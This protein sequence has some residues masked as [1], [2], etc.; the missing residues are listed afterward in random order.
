MDIKNQKFLVLGASKSG[1]SVLKY[2]KEKGAECRVYEE[3]KNPKAQ[4][5]VEKLA[6]LGIK[7]V[8]KEIAEDFLTCVDVL[9]LSPG[10]PINHELAV[11]AKQLGKRIVGELEFAYLQFLPLIVAVT[12]TNGKTTT[13]TL[14]DETLHNA[15]VKSELLGNVGVPFTSK[16]CDISGEVVCVAE[17]SSF[18]LESTFAFTPH[19]SCVINI[20]PDHL[21]RHY[22]MENYVFLKKRIFKNQRESE[23]AVLNFDDPIV[24]GF[25][26][27]VKAKVI[28][29]SLR[30]VVDGA[31]RKDGKLYYKNEYVID[32]NAL[33]LKGE[34]NVYNALFAIAVTKILGVESSIIKSSLET[35]KGVKHRV[36]LVCEKNGVEYY[37]DSKATNTA[38]TIS[39]IEAINKPLVLILGGSEKGESYDALFEKIKQSEIRQVVITGAT[40]FSMLDCASRLGVNDITVTEDFIS[41]VKISALFARE[42][43]A[44]LLS[45]A[46]ASFDKFSGFEERG[47]VFVKAVEEL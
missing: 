32:E 27:E 22:S 14:I 4:S 40:R 18:Q 19:I 10:V 11:K 2:L 24:K 3:L 45:P 33:K 17:V 15:K 47:E 7:S 28:W 6:E 5:A 36:E 13:V 8:S 46:C 41:A 16:V 12:G 23:F 34:H 26:P 37:N 30:D 31:Y 39:A 21:E 9:V 35:F 25:Y 29:V 44:V 43:D 42:G 1:F 20:A 38:S